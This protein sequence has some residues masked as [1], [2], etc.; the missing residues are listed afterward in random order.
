MRIVFCGSEPLLVRTPARAP[1][2]V[3]NTE[4]RFPAGSRVLPPCV[5]VDA[6]E[7]EG[8]LILER[9]GA[10]GVVAVPYG[11]TDEE[12][13]LKGKSIRHDMLVRFIHAYREDQAV[14]Q[15]AGTGVLLP[16]QQHRDAMREIKQL[17]ADILAQDEVLAGALP[18]V[19]PEPTVDPLAKELA[20]FGL[21]GA[22]PMAPGVPDSLLGF[23]EAGV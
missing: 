14:R 1:L 16:R 15:A 13:I 6:T 7:T 19:A 20:S 8:A 9:F 5:V 23:A 18:A 2:I 10:A 4:L 22:A 21:T 3:A 11:V 12:A 17:S